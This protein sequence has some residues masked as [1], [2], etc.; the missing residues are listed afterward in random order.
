MKLQQ[1]SG[2]LNTKDSSHLIKINEATQYENIDNEGGELQPCKALVA[3]GQT[4]NENDR[5]ITH[6]DTVTRL[7]KTPVDLLEYQNKIYYSVEDDFI[8][9]KD[10]QG[11]IPT[12]GD[13]G[14][15]PPEITNLSLIAT[16]VNIPEESDITIAENS[17]DGLF[18]IRRGTYFEG[19]G[20]VLEFALIRLDEEGNQSNVLYFEYITIAHLCTLQIS[21]PYDHFIHYRSGGIWRRLIN[22]YSIVIY[23][24]FSAQDNGSLTG[25]TTTPGQANI[26][27]EMFWN[28]FTVS[29]RNIDYL[30]RDWQ[31]YFIALGIVDENNDIQL[32]IE[33][34]LTPLN[35]SLAIAGTYV[36]VATLGISNLGWE[37]EPSNLISA[38]ITDSEI[39]EFIINTSSDNDG[40]PYIDTRVDKLYIYRL[41]NTITD[42]TLLRTIDDPNSQ[43]P[44]IIIDREPDGSISGNTILS[45][46]DYDKPLSGIKNLA[47]VNGQLVGTLEGK[48]YFSITGKLFAIPPTNYRDFKENLTGLFEID[49]G[50][51]VCSD[52]KTWL[53]NTSNLATG[54]I[55]QLSSEFGCINHNAIAGIKTGAMWTST[56]GF[57]SSFGGKVELITKS[58]I[59]YTNLDIIYALM[60][61]E[62]YFGFTESGICYALDLRYGAPVLKT[63]NFELFSD[64]NILT[65][66]FQLYIE[67]LKLKALFGTVSI[68]DSYTLFNSSELEELIWKSPKFI[69]G[70][71]TDLKTYKDIYVYATDKIIFTVYIDDIKVSETKFKKTDNHH[72]KVE[73]EKHQGYSIQFEAIGKGK[74]Y[75]IEY[76]AMGSQDGR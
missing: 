9:M 6:L 11:I 69:E 67:S 35:E 19:P 36:Y 26:A 70:A 47:V 43:W 73:H 66:I 33:V 10:V 72:I 68:I 37:S 2:G 55:L 21:V 58:K 48:L 42:F 23:T 20:L 45:T 46:E 17:F 54:K 60:Y 59:G 64:E 12:E 57:C 32:H 27:Y 63:F 76:K 52:T 31:L 49:A 22:A 28:D 29:S 50:L 15:V 53:I 5:F 75:E 7:T 62:T 61:N 56:E 39:P 1:F 8:Q 18:D 71:F 16:T 13:L 41:G 25:L 44:I 14:L 24:V 38:I 34:D 74:I 51:I 3:A 30:S 40:T 65:K 4:Y